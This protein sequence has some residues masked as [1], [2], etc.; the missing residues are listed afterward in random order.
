VP[1]IAPHCRPEAEGSTIE[2]HQL[3]CNWPDQAYVQWG[4]PGLGFAHAR[5]ANA[6]AF[7]EVFPHG[8]ETFIRAEGTTVEEAE[9][10]AYDQF[11]RQLACPEHTFGRGRYTNGAGVCEHCGMF[12]PDVF[13]EL[14]RQSS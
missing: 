13:E 12:K 4:R 8:S 2:Q 1:I 11:A 5:R 7:F 6:K 9:R 10:A 3:A 14:P